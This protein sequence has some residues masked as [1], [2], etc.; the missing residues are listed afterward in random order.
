MKTALRAIKSMTLRVQKG[1]GGLMEK[2]VYSLRS[3]NPVLSII[4]SSEL[5]KKKVKKRDDPEDI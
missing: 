4:L 1:R 2:N 5:G 3:G